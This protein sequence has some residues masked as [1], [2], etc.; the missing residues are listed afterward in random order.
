MAPSP[1]AESTPTPS[2]S[3]AA[4][5]RES[6]IPSDT[7]TEYATDSAWNFLIGATNPNATDA[8][9]AENQFNSLPPDGS[10][11][12]MAPVYIKVKETADA[13]EG[14]SPGG[15]LNFG[16]VTAAGNT[17]D[18]FSAPCGV[19]PND[20][21]ALG[22]MYAGAEAYANICVAVPRDAVSGGT[23]KV[24]SVVDPSASIF[25]DGAP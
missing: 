22:A 17:F 4:G 15:S 16:Y 25:I 9:I 18:M 2:P 5:T 10:V 13:P 11:F 7:L 19:I 8:V 12:I 6:P 14:I 21:L 3:V 1:E 23:W 20:V 24:T